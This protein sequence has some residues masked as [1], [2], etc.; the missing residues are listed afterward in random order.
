[1][2]VAHLNT[3]GRPLVLVDGDIVFQPR[4]IQRFGIW[5]RSKPRHDLPAQERVLV[6]FARYPRKHY[7]FST[8]AELFVLHESILRMCTDEP[9]FVRQGHYASPRVQ[10]RG[11]GAR[12][13]VIERIE[14]L[15]TPLSDFQQR[16]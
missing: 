5:M 13:L 12:T 8:K 9:V 10:L 6:I 4:K 11:S 15:S 14:D 1:M 7:V 2:R 3:S 16:P